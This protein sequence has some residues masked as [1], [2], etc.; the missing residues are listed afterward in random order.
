MIRRTWL[1][2][3]VAVVAVVVTSARQAWAVS[4][5]IEVFVTDC[6]DLQV[7]EVERVLDIE[8]SSVA[9]EWRGEEKLRAELSCDP[10]H[11]SIVVTDPVTDKKLSRTVAMQWRSADRDRTVALLV[12]Q[13]F[14]TSWSELLLA[15]DAALEPP[16]PPAS[17][18]VQRAAAAMVR[19]SM[20]PPATRWAVSLLVGSRVRELPA[21]LVSGDALLRPSLSFGRHAF[22]FLDLGYE[23][24]DATRAPGAVVFSL[25][26]ASVGAGWRHVFGTLGLEAD[27]RG[28]V[29]YVDLQGNP[30][31]SA[32]GVAASGAVGEG[33]IELGP[34][35]FLGHARLGL[36]A[37]A[38]ATIA[39]AVAHVAGDRDVNLSG[40]WFGANL[41]A[42]F[43]ES[44]P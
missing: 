9:N 17:P 7:P 16:R 19:S 32:S 33:A 13:L 26:S 18:A 22:V 29:A 38:G 36:L 34:T 20:E 5:S 27:L 40:A 2:A 41:V 8:L 43:L 12:S 39:P 24:G 25:A 28:G 11:L 21:P 31:G 15:R 37:S 1:L 10:G 14:L 42:S 44:G 30:I 6:P 23:R 3:V 4:P 35:L